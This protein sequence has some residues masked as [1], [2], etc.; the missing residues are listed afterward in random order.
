MSDVQVSGTQ[1]A[2]VKMT[3]N[4][5]KLSKMEPSAPFAPV[6]AYFFPRFT[7]DDSDVQFPLAVGTFSIGMYRNTKDN[8][9]NWKI[10]QL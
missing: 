8:Y 2:G 7:G 3:K 9:Q 6:R 5:E 1:F 4:M 10:L